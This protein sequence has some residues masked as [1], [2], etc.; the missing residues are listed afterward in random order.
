MAPPSLCRFDSPEWLGRV[1]VENLRDVAPESILDLGSGGGALSLAALSRWPGRAVVTV[2]IDAIAGRQIRHAITAQNYAA[3]HRHVVAD[4]LKGPLRK[5]GG[6]EAGTL[7]LVI[8]N[9]PYRTARWTPVIASILK[10]AGFPE[11]SWSER[12]I[13]VDLV[14]LAQAMRFVRP[15]GSLGLV[16]PDSF[17]SGRRMSVFRQA[18]LRS[19]SVRRV[20]QLPRG[21]FKNTD[22]QAYIM[23]VDHGCPENYVQLDRINADGTTDATVTVPAQGAIER[24]DYGFHACTT[25]DHGGFGS[26][27][28]SLGVTVHRGQL[29]SKQIRDN[30]DGT[31]HTSDFQSGNSGLVALSA[32]RPID[33]VVGVVA[34]PGD[35]LLARVDRRLEKKIAMV[36][37]GRAHLSDCVFRLRCPIEVR[38]R[39]FEGL[40]SHAGQAQLSNL[41]RGTGARHISAGSVLSVIV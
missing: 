24:M 33:G 25:G 9:P 23:V 28:R 8:S 10:R 39:V 4:V 34:E 17:V 12:D 1:L 31:F 32:E 27:L 14:F 16:L 21:A 37:S 26:S 6:M 20:I 36:S 35:I 5:L 22:A 40:R 30:A 7:D 41:S 13:P 15:G 11:V 3:K 18:L 19:H 29:N 38:Q 2:D